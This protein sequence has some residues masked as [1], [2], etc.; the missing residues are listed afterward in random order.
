VSVAAESDIVQIRTEYQAIR[1]AL[2]NLKVETV[3]LNGISTEGADAKAYRDGK[4]CPVNQ[5]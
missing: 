1:A 5:G 3:T 4:E 2:P